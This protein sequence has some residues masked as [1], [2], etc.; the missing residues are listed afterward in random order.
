MTTEIKGRGRA[1][2]AVSFLSFLALG[3]TASALGPAL[4]ELAARTGSGL[5]VLGGIFTAM[6]GGSV[7]AQA[8]S[9][10]LSTGLAHA[11]SCWSV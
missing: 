8:L 11:P 10:P 5:A 3:M 7:T 1:L 6:F 9:G 2:L 4:P